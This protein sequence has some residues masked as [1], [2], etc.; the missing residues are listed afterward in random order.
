M[1]KDF[2]KK[3]IYP[4]KYSTEAYIKF[5]RSGGGKIGEIV[6]FMEHRR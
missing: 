3:L 2:F 4:H 5:I 6:N 1:F